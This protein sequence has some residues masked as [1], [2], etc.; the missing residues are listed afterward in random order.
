M[1]IIVVGGGRL[2]YYLTKGLLAEGHEVLLLEKE[3]EVCET[4]TE[5][6]GSVCFRGD[7]CE[8]TT[9]N[10]VGTSRADMFI[11]VTGDD[12]DNMVSCQVAKH[13]FNVPTTIARL[14]NP[15]N[16]DLFKKLGI[17]ITISATNLILEAIEREVTT[18]PLTHILTM[19]DKG[20]EM[21]DI[22]ILPESTS[23]GKLVRELALPAESKLTLVIPRENKPYVPTANSVLKEGDRVIA[24]TTPQT[25]EALRA[26]LSGA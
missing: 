6:L 15:D 16:E 11:A 20:W 14:R 17:N 12:E 2:G 8:T 5:E 24:L 10:E 19:Q 23:A 1:Y 21:V 4:I 7:G 3:S 18:H 26:A 9:L 25:E 13:K 22:R